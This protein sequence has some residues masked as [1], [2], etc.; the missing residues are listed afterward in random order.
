MFR[1][2]LA[3]LFLSAVPI[4]CRTHVIDAFSQALLFV[5]VVIIDQSDRT[6][7]DNALRKRGFF[8]ELGRL[9]IK[10]FSESSGCLEQLLKSG[11]LFTINHHQPFLQLGQIVPQFNHFIF[12]MV[13]C[14]KFVQIVFKVEFL[15][16]EL[17]FQ[18]VAFWF[19]LFYCMVLLK[20]VLFLWLAYWC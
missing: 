20:N 8:L 10:T 3:G 5:W 15:F 9:G 7:F 18:L 4:G 16:F 17:V 6:H 12:T 1:N 14:L 19:E 13:K 2:G 11:P